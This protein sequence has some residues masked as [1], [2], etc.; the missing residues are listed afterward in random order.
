MNMFSGFDTQ[1]LADALNID[2]QTAQQLQGQ[3]D[4]RPQIIRVEGRFD[5][6]EPPQSREEERQ[7]QGQ[8]RQQG[9]NGFEEVFCHM[10]IKQNI[11]KPSL[12]DVFSPQAGRIS[13]LNSFG[14]PILKFLRLSA[15]RGFLYNVSILYMHVLL[16][17]VK[18]N[19]D[20]YL[21][22]NAECYPQPPLELERP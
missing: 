13:T 22:G 14:M 1:L 17:M 18:Y 2:Q 5:F 21:V 16:Y 6:V 15:E 20:I 4:N 7:L 19:N 8:Q 12:A 10:K 9:Q 3:N 11:G